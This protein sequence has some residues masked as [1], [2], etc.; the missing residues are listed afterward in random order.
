MNK[1]FYKQMFSFLLDTYLCKI[2][3]RT[4]FK[5]FRTMF[6]VAL[7]LSLM[8]PCYWGVILLRSLLAYVTCPVKSLH[9]GWSKVKWSLGLCKFSELF[10]SQ[11]LTV[12]LPNSCEVFP[13]VCVTRSSAVPSRGP[14]ADSWS[15]L[16][17]QIPLSKTLPY[18]FQLH[19]HF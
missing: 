13:S 5:T 11:L 17:I 16:S 19:Q 8:G 18:I 10:T 14:S 1:S 3:I 9:S 12:T 7:T 15:S 6:I 4:V 2:S